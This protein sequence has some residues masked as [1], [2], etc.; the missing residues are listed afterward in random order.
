MARSDEQ[1]L[2][3]E[4]AEE[5][6]VE[7]GDADEL[8][9]GERHERAGGNRMVSEAVAGRGDPHLDARRPRVRLHAASLPRGRRVLLGVRAAAVDSRASRGLHAPEL[10]LPAE[11]GRHRLCT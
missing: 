11:P 5:P 3:E 4:M 9:A 8:A 1:Q 6:R 10:S 7:L 2:D